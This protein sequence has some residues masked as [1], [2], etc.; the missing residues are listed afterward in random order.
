M[1]ELLYYDT[2][3]FVQKIDFTDNSTEVVANGALLSVPVQTGLSST[4]ARTAGPPPTFPVRKLG[5]K[6]DWITLS[7][8]EIL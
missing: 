2:R 1:I 8:Q 3:S 4:T 7:S 6:G 5:I